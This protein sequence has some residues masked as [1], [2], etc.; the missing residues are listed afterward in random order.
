MRSRDSSHI[1]HR[2]ARFLPSRL[3]RSQTV[4]ST[5]RILI[6]AS[7]LS[8]CQARRARIAR[9]SPTRPRLAGLPV[10][11]SPRPRLAPP[12]SL[13]SRAAASSRRA[14]SATDLKPY[15]PPSL[16]P[17]CGRG[18]QRSCHRKVSRL[19][20][21]QIKTARRISPHATGAALLTRARN[22]IAQS[23][24]GAVA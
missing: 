14:L 16:R 20:P 24:H 11:R 3:C 4:P 12:P 6:T 23:G 18:L 10:H 7:S 9:P 17:A 8:A 19:P 15:P 21:Q 2:A 1:Q 5:L 13:A 22:S